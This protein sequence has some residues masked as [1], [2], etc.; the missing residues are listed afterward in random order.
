MQTCLPPSK[1]FPQPLACEVTR[2]ISCRLKHQR[3]SLNPPT[4]TRDVDTKTLFIQT[5]QTEHLSSRFARCLG[6]TEFQL[7]KPACRVFSAS[8]SLSEGIKVQARSW[9]CFYQCFERPGV[10]EAG[11][12]HGKFIWSACFGLCSFS[13]V[14][15]ESRSLVC[16]LFCS[17]TNPKFQTAQHL[18]DFFFAIS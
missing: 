13:W 8:W 2:G 10:L 4:I 14:I 16:F 17:S 18:L 15:R 3:Q 7:P 9:L 11:A 6:V 1:P 12:V 5:S